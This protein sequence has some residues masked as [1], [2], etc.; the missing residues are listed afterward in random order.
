MGN[1]FASGKNAIGVCDRCGQTFMLKELKKLT[2]KLKQTSIKVCN[3]CWE[4]DQPQWQTG[5]LRI[6]D[7]QALREPRVQQSV[8]QIRAITANVPQ[9]R[10]G[11]SY[12]G[13]VTVITA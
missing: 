8:G 11:A 10:G 5:M 6:V 1:T 2:I 13:N 3:E 9:I 12:L 4:P 7:A